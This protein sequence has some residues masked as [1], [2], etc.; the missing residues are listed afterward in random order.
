MN[1]LCVNLFLFPLFSDQGLLL[2]LGLLAAGAA[3]QDWTCAEVSVAP[4]MRGTEASSG[5]GCHTTAAT[6][7]VQ[8]EGV[9]GEV[10]LYIEQGHGCPTISQWH[11]QRTCADH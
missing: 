9:G 4:I 11:A 10:C 7:C 6:L 1:I 3:G 5:C 2:S 8:C